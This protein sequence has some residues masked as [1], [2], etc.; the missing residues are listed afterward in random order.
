MDRPTL[1]IARYNEDLSWL[2]DVPS[3]Y[4]IIVYN[5]S[6]TPCDHPICRNITVKQLTNIGKEA[7]TYC[8]YILDNYDALPETIVF[9]QGDP[10]PH[11]PDFLKLLG[12]HKSWTGFQALTSR[13]VDNIPPVEVFE[14]FSKGSTYVERMSCYSLGSVRFHDKGVAHLSDA[15]LRAYQLPQGTNIMKHHFEAIGAGHLIHEE[16]EVI[17]FNYSAIFAVQARNV[18]AHCPIIYENMIGRLKHPDWFEPSIS[19]RVW[20]TLFSSDAEHFQK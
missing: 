5:K 1:V 13:Y 8:R 6:Q 10:F 14:K 17:P 16:T 20:M 12:Q 19:E 7:D 3:Q 18:L 9:S 2:V 15:Y 4:N 11:S